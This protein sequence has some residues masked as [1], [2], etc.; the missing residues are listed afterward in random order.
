MHQTKRRTKKNNERKIIFGCLQKDFLFFAISSTPPPPLVPGPPSRSVFPGVDDC[1]FS[2][3]RFPPPSTVPSIPI[4]PF[5]LTV[6]S[7]VNPVDNIIR[8]WFKRHEPAFVLLE[9]VLLLPAQIGNVHH[10]PD[11]GVRTVGYHLGGDGGVHTGH[12]QVR[13]NVR[14]VYVNCVGT[15][16]V[17]ETLVITVGEGGL[18]ETEGGRGERRVSGGREVGGG[19]RWGGGGENWGLRIVFWQ[20]FTLLAF[21]HCAYRRSTGRIS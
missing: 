8:G 4:M 16:K 1:F 7:V 15:T 3:C 2:L 21:N 14:V 5:Q 11:R 19:E 6:K 9:Y 12:F 20:L 17:G 13:A 18:G 10:V